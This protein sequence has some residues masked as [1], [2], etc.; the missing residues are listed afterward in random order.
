MNLT[1]PDTIKRL[2]SR[3]GTDFSKAL[4]QNFIIDDTVCP[5]MAANCGVNKTSGVIEIGTGV[6]VLTRELSAVAGKVV[7]I[8]LDTSLLPILAE[9]LVDCHNVFVRN[10][11]FLE[12]D[13]QKL[14][15]EEFPDMDVF[16]CANLPYYITSPIIMKLLEA[17]A[18]IKSATLMV[19]QEAADRI[20]AS[21]GSRE[22]GVLTVA[23]NFYAEAERLFQVNRTSFMPSPK[24]DSSV[25]K[26]TFKE[27]TVK[28]ADEKQ[29]FRVVKAAFS[30]RR[31]TAANSLSSGLSMPKEEITAVLEQC[32]LSPTIR[33]E[34]LTMDELVEISDILYKKTID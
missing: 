26:L 5:R 24:V 6:G 16:V 12:T 8:E 14:I 18:R 7:A 20:C 4:G 34:V 28:V 13:L 10:Q 15:D 33:P 27:N 21:V 2:L 23:V 31:K 29:F 1:S 22:S 9:T 11:D 25:I 19:Q 30:Q 17:R 32:G 3:H